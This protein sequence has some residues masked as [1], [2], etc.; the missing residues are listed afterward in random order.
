MFS[1]HSSFYSFER[2]TSPCSILSFNILCG[3]FSFLHS[4]RTFLFAYSFCCASRLW[5]IRFIVF[6]CVFA[7]SFYPC[8]TSSFNLGLY[9]WHQLFYK[10]LHF[11]RLVAL[12]LF[13]L[14]RIYSPV[15]FVLHILF[16]H[17]CY[18]L[19]LK[20]FILFAWSY[21]S[22]FVFFAYTFWYILLFEFYLKSFR[23]NI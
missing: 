2:L 19:V 6:F 18:L 7:Q 9:A 1:M 8:F 10:L 13:C 3:H 4:S 21:Y 20:P 12:F 15:H 16:L 5:L 22:L 14:I 17:A 23:L 11:T